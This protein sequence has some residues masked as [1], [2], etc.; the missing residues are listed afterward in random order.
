MRR[1]R[2]C[3]SGMFS[4]EDE[5]RTWHVRVQTSGFTH[6]VDTANHD[7]SVD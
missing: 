4:V 6:E 3:N 1:F 5:S 2:D 7:E